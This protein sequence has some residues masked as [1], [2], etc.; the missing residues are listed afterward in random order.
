MPRQASRPH[1]RE[2]T[3]RHKIIEYLILEEELSAKA[4]SKLVSVS[5][6]EIYDHLF[7]IYQTINRD[8]T[9]KF[10]L[11]PAE[12]RRCNYIF[13][14]RNKLKKPSSCPECHSQLIDAPLFSIIQLG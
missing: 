11:L 4:L 8:K 5:E 3:I 1:Q 10:V 12:C 6:K 7:H 13:E 2:E 9:K 14:K